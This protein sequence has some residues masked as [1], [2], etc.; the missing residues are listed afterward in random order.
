MTE[1]VHDL[2]D[3]QSYRNRPDL[4]HLKLKMNHFHQKS[5]ST[6]TPTAKMFSSKRN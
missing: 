2:P 6:V 4:T 1:E 3:I 5:C